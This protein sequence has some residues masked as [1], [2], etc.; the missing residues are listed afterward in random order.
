[1]R[2]G[3]P[4]ASADTSGRR[5]PRRCSPRIH[6]PAV[7]DPN[8]VRCLPSPQIV[9]KPVGFTWD[10]CPPGFLGFLGF[11][12]AGIPRTKIRGLVSSA[13]SGVIAVDGAA[14]RAP[15]VYSGLS[16]EL[17]GNGLRIL[18]HRFYSIADS[19][20]SP[21]LSSASEPDG[22]ASRRSRGRFRDVVGPAHPL[23]TFN[24]R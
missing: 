19:T 9:R 20:T 13:A 24:T 6:A 10:F 8:A 17:T 2:L 18:Q 3:C 11:L 23:T 15:A 1:M 7:S 4:C 22:R 12:S 5:V 14:C 16:A 21:L